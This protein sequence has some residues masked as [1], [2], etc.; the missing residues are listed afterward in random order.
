[1]VPPTPED[2]VG[3]NPGLATRSRAEIQ[4][5]IDTIIA[6]GWRWDTRS[7]AFVNDTLGIWL[8]TQGLDLFTPETFER[9]HAEMIATPK[10]HA[11]HYRGTG[12]FKRW[13]TVSLLLLV[14]DLL[15][16]WLVFAIRSWLLSLLMLVIV[17]VLLYRY[18]RAGVKAIERQKSAGGGQ[19]AR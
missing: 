19:P 9:H 5:L 2:L 15:F 13:G 1:M 18:A 11:R 14:L 8:R 4:R 6:A 10:L 12:V 17:L 3:L 7:V 16:G